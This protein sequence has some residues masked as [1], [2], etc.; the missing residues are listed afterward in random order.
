MV[1]IRI[2]MGAVMGAQ[3]ARNLHRLWIY[4][5]VFTMYFDFFDS[6][7]REFALRSI[8]LAREDWLPKE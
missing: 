4:L 7:C 3:E 8:P 5:N 6:G 2:V 1:G